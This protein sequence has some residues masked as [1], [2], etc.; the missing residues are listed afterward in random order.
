MNIKGY[1]ICIPNNFITV[2]VNVQHVFSECCN[3]LVHIVLPTFSPCRSTCRCSLSVLP[4]RSQ[5]KRAKDRPACFLTLYKYANLNGNVQAAVSYSCVCVSP[6]RLRTLMPASVSWQPKEST[7]RVCLQRVSWTPALLAFTGTKRGRPKR[8]VG[9]A[10]P[11]LATKQMSFYAEA[12]KKK[13]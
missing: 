11:G 10:R 1:M 2:I 8:T 3:R 12:K 9:Q 4:L 7:S 13:N 6:S 5:E